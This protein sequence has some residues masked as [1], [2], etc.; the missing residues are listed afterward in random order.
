MKKQ[1]FVISG[2]VV[3]FTMLLAACNSQAATEGTNLSVTNSLLAGSNTYTIASSNRSVTEKASDKIES[4]QTS[5]QTK[6][7]ASSTKSRTSTKSNTQTSKK[8]SKVASQTSASKESR[9]QSSHHASS[10][11]VSLITSEIQ[12]IVAAPQRSLHVGDTMRLDAYIMPANATERRE[13]RAEVSDLDIVEVVFPYSE[14]YMYVK[15]LKAGEC[16]ITFISPNGVTAQT[17]VIV[18]EKAES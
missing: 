7:S 12:H 10:S 11:T 13:V 1:W 2:M 8:T 3:L 14:G 9:L 17:K 5:V 6:P 4:S 15:G 18:T 16:T